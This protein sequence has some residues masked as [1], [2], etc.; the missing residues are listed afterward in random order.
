MQEMQTKEII[1][2]PLLLGDNAI[3][4][5][6]EKVRV[7]G[8][9]DLAKEGISKEGEIDLAG[10]DAPGKVNVAFAKNAKGQAEKIVGTACG[11]APGEIAGTP[12]DSR[13][14]ADII[15]CAASGVALKQKENALKMSESLTVRLKKEG[16][17][18]AEAV[19]PVR[20]KTGAFDG[21]LPETPAGTGYELEFSA[22]S[23]VKTV[24]NVAF[25]RVILAGGQSNMG[26]RTFQ[27]YNKDMSLL[28]EK[29]IAAANDNEI[30]LFGVLRKFSDKKIDDVEASFSGGWRVLSPEIAHDFGAIAFFFAERLH[31]LTKEPVGVVMSCMGGVPI[32]SWMSE[33]SYQRL[34]SQGFSPVSPQTPEEFLPAS[35]FNGNIYPLRKFRFSGLIWYQ[36]EGDF[37]RY[38]E[39]LREMVCGWRRSLR[40]PLPMA[41][42]GMH[43]METETETYAKCRDE[44]K[45][46]VRMLKNATYTT[47]CDTGLPL[48]RIGEK[49]DL[50]TG[51][52]IHPY[53]KKVVGYRTAE[54]FYGAFLG[55]KELSDSPQPVSVMRER[56]KI[57]LRLKNVGDGL[58]LQNA[59]GFY[60]E[61]GEDRVRLTPR[62]IK[63]D[64]IE[65]SGVPEAAETLSYGRVFEND[66]GEKPQSMRDCFS[67][68]NSE[69]GELRY[70][71]DSFRI[72]LKG[73]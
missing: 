13:I 25:G 41:D 10:G 1:H 26:W 59:A 64:E 6:G 70:P 22:C 16:K 20:Q 24:K 7:W 54:R 29:E 31:E 14:A 12:K 2:L 56:G 44:H 67:V 18:V 43:T 9:I 37:N 65:F 33:S 30:R 28:Y 3:F 46:G 63:K 66:R 61:T 69:N 51:T 42:C 49:D 58:L 62:L 60:A 38:G 17:T 50:N 34:L 71:L 11:N 8:K 39:R 19:L 52:G 32:H 21:Y 40:Q 68:Y 55:G 47:I 73:L 23:A 72:Q 15:D 53:D 36:G 48:C 57:R 35:Y 45:T 4:A 27:C 5:A